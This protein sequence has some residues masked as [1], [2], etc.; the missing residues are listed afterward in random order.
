M[1]TQEFQRFVDLAKPSDWRT[2]REQERER[3]PEGVIKAKQIQE[4][5]NPQ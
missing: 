5:W 2:E 3:E 4:D 1:T